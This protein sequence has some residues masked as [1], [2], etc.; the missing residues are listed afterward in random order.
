[1]MP[2]THQPRANRL[3]KSKVQTG[4]SDRDKQKEIHRAPMGQDFDPRQYQYP[5]LTEKD[6]L[7]L[8]EVFDSFDLNGDGFIAPLELRAA[9]LK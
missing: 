1:M 4:H 9:L 6:V 3:M 7:D 8:K 5:G 2:K